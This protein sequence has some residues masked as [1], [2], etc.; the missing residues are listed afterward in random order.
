MKMQIP[1]ALFF[2]FLLVGVIAT[3]QALQQQQQQQ[4]QPYLTFPLSR[5]TMNE[6]MIT[7]SSTSSDHLF[8]RGAVRGGDAGTVKLC[9]KLFASTTSS[10]SRASWEEAAM[11]MRDDEAILKNVPRWW[12]VA[13]LNVFYA[14]LTFEGNQVR[15]G[16]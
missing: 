9:Y 14:T 13:P 10:L 1:F 12:T 15:G 6:I 3:D 11:L 4:P 7:S 2:A 16:T 5:K 8:L